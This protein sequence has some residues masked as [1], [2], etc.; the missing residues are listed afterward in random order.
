MPEIYT[1]PLSKII[2]ELQLEA[3]YLPK[4]ADD[5]LIQSR[6]VV[7][8]GMELSGYL[9]YFDPK[10][11]AVIGRAET[12][13]VQSWR[14]DKRSIAL[15][16]YFSQQPPAVIFARGIEP[17]EEMHALAVRYGVPLLRTT[18]STS[19]IVASLVAY[20]NVELAPRITRHGVSSTISMP[21]LSSSS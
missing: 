1:L 4:S 16:S 9:E 15:E 3:T 13:M 21:L 17:S 2:H 18:E 10:R 20:L 6:D 11:I 8:P 14:T 7:R 19:N 5:I 12:A